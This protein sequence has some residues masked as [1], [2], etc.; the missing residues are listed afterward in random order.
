MPLGSASTTTWGWWVAVVGGGWSVGV[1]A[2]KLPV[3]WM[4][5]RSVG[6]WAGICEG[7]GVA[8]CLRRTGQGFLTWPAL[9]PALVA[10]M[11]SR[12]PLHCEAL[13]TWMLA[14]SFLLCAA[15]TAGN[16]GH[17]ILATPLARP[18]PP[19]AQVPWRF[20]K[21]EEGRA[22]GAPLPIT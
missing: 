8:G 17:A 2:G 6:G 21:G 11:D 20:E 19:P 13:C 14:A 3:G 18:S 12:V 16:G 9:C 22:V 7:G 10:V 15:T 4:G 5:A 1:P